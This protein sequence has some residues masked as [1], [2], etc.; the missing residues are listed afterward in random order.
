MIRKG[1]RTLMVLL[2]VTG[3]CGDAIA[4]YPY[5]RRPDLP[6]ELQRE[7]SRISNPTAN[8][9]A[10]A[11]TPEA[12]KKQT[13]AVG[14]PSLPGYG[15]GTVPGA[16][17]RPSA[18]PGS[19]LPGAALP[20]GTSVPPQA[21]PAVGQPL[22]PMPLLNPYPQP[23]PRANTGAAVY[24]QHNPVYPQE[25]PFADYKAPGAFSPYMNLYRRDTVP[26]MDN[27][28]MY[29]KPAIEAQ[30]QE[31]TARQQAQAARQQQAEAQRAAEMSRLPQVGASYGN[32]NSGASGTTYGFGTLPPTP[33]AADVATPGSDTS[34]E[35]EKGTDQET[36]DELGTVRINLLNPYLPAGTGTG[37]PTKVIP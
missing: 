3:V 33:P 19:T 27:Y 32:L 23:Q 1:S 7:S 8:P 25:K 34:A 6:P 9:Y 2:V 10:P 15:S 26:G 21:T 14:T 18:M 24:G 16:G 28:T 36:E 30:Q 35:K 11:K 13:P 5:G 17:V 22:K 31:A 37:T 20:T 12:P 29:V 4:Q